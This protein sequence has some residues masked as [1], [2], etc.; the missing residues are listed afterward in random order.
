MFPWNGPTH[1]DGNSGSIDSLIAMHLRRNRKMSRDMEQQLPKGEREEAGVRDAELLCSHYRQAFLHLLK[2]QF[3]D[4][5]STLKRMLEVLAT[6]L[7]VDRVSFWVFSDDGTTIR[8]AHRVN[9]VQLDQ[10]QPLVLRQRDYPQYFAAISRQ[11]VVAAEDAMQDPRTAELSYTYLTAL[12]IRSMLDVP[13]RA[14]GRHLGIL[15]HE[16]IVG[17]RRWSVEDQNFASGVAM[18]IALAYE[19]DHA[20]RTQDS[21]LQRSLHDPET[22]LPNSMH[23]DNMV[24]AEL[25]SGGANGE[26]SVAMLVTSV[27]QYKYVLGALG[28]QRMQELVRRFAAQIRS[29]SPSRAIVARTAP[30]EF[31]LF[32]PNVARDELPQLIEAWTRALTT[33]LMSGEQ[34]LFL[35]LS[36]GY[37]F[38]SAGANTTAEL[39]RTEAHLAALDARNEGGDRIKPF[40]PEMRERLLSRAIVEQD[41]RR[42]LDARE[43]ALHFQPIIDLATGSCTSVEALLRWE[44]PERGL[45][46]PADFLQVALDSGVML[47]LGR[48][49]LR[50]GCE[51]L[52]QLRRQTGIESLTLSLNMS[53]PEILMPGTCEAIH[54]ELQRVQLPPT[55]LTIEITESALMIDMDRASDAVREIRA[56]G[57][58]I[59]LDDFGTAFS[60]L[61]W[62]RRLPIDV[63]KID[64]S[65]VAGIAHDE[66]DVAIVKSIVALAQAFE[67]TVVAEG[68]ENQA[69]CDALSE[70]GLNFGQGFLFAGPASV[71]KFTHTWLADV[72][73]RAAQSRSI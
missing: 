11:L 37:S 30:N 29:V 43:F 2:E 19:R 8:C 28:A 62:L 41:L 22:Q 27:D 5:D 10:D 49:V 61:S 59:G 50:A 38:C 64:R 46:F 47:E 31:A 21:L 66:R 58:R 55:S 54:C 70:M 44:H 1:V 51:G 36:T 33:P 15:C 24:D 69:Q 52:A 42:A 57:V 3:T 53:A 20:K 65:F 4:L 26:G 60:S 12:G 73:R 72:T 63:I 67:Q 13:V 48:R 35:T 16:N 23:L 39:L 7:D 17:V 9:R 45:L 32:L 14:F 25:Q 56:S 34:K 18:Q 68:I 71:D 40:A 6:T